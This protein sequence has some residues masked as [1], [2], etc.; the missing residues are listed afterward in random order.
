MEYKCDKCF[1]L[2]TKKSNLDNHLKRKRPCDI[3]T[4]NDSIKCEYCNLLINHSRNI[5]RHLKSC[6]EYKKISFPPK[7]KEEVKINIYGEEKVE[8]ITQE[9]WRE[10]LLSG[11][12]SLEKLIKLYHFNLEHPENMNLHLINMNHRDY[13]FFK[14]NKDNWNVSIMDK[15]LIEKLFADKMDMIL[16]K[17]DEIKVS[18]RLRRYIE[19]LSDN[20]DNGEDSESYKNLKQEILGCLINVTNTVKE[21]RKNEEK[22][23]KNKTTS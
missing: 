23:K 6:K 11:F 3:S 12:R 4:T 20:L 2:F 15:F 5:N 16:N 14:E 22:R 17:L 7:V 13:I 1:K 9:V 10:I 18:E 8:Y 21:N 19:K